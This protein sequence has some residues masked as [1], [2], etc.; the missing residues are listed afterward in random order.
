MQSPATVN[1]LESFLHQPN[2]EESPAWELI[3]GQ[4][5][6]KPMPLLFHSVVQFN[7][8]G[9]INRQT[10]AYYAVAEL[11][12]IVPPL[13]SVPD[14]SVIA[15]ERLPEEDG[16]FV[17][18]PDW[19]IEILS[20]AQSTLQL[21]AKIIHFLNA[22]TQLA[23]LIDTKRQQVWVWEGEELPHVCSAQESLP[24]LGIFEN[25]TVSAVMDMTRRR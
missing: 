15:V 25:L 5:I 24:T 22:G 23:W 18:A 1:L 7:L 2:I 6:Q 4:A 16:P 13:S 9:D 11:R 10:R 19:I 3:N 21:Q 8:T 20:P 12:C 14:I 17:G